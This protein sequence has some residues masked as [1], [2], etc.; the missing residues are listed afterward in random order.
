[1]IMAEIIALC[2]SELNVKK[3]VVLKCKKYYTF[4]FSCWFICV[5]FLKITFKIWF[6]RLNWI[7]VK[8]FVCLKKWILKLKLLLYE[9]LSFVEIIP[10]EMNLTPWARISF[11]I[12]K[13]YWFACEEGYQNVLHFF[14]THF[15]NHFIW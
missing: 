8:S 6:N 4:F 12:L 3:K 7:F 9:S 5:Y 2:I 14:H 10:C 13:C 11:I 15:L 1:M